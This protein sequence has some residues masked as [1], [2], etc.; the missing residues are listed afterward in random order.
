[1]VFKICVWF[2]DVIFDLLINF[3]NQTRIDFV[4]E[5]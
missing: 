5:N 4:L 1:M 3:G 2:S